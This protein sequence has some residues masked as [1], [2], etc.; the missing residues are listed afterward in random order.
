MTGSGAAVFA[1]YDS[2]EAA[3]GVLAQLPPDMSGF[4]ARGLDR[5]PLWDLV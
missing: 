5:H 2:G 1:A 4:V 3:Q